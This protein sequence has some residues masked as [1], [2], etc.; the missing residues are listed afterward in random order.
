[1]PF[2]A[3]GVVIGTA[4]LASPESFAHDYHKERIVTAR[5]QET[6]LTDMFHIN[7]P[8]GAPVRVL[9]NS[10]TQGLRGDPFGPKSVIG[11]EEGRPIYLF[12]TDSPLRSMTGD[13]EAMAL[14]AGQ[15]VDR[16]DA[17]IPVGDRLKA[18][19]A[20]AQRLLS[21]GCE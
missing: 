19:V 20:E 9:Q 8:I 2:G 21:A 12:S 17:I 6:F 14:Y 4:F 10:A 15:G 13:F 18:I 1:M 7:W 5:S 16:I 3:D 11:E